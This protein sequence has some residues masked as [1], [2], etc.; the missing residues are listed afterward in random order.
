M[1]TI[2]ISVYSIFI[3]SLI[4]FCWLW[5][6]WSL[7]AFSRALHFFILPVADLQ[8]TKWFALLLGLV[9]AIINFD[10]FTMQHYT[11]KI[12]S[13]LFKIWWMQSK[14][15]LCL[16]LERIIKFFRFTIDSRGYFRHRNPS[17][18]VQWILCVY[19]CTRSE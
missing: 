5:V 10:T 13:I 12:N 4:L 3:L 11:H 2:Y 1:S 18:V 15:I 8:I 16:L 9:I 6:C 7:C 14:M 17:K 19:V